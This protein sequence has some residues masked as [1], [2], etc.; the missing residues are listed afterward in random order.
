MMVVTLLAIC[1]MVWIMVYAQ[2]SATTALILMTLLTLFWMVIS[3]ENN[4]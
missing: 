4:E 3:D 2:A 1:F